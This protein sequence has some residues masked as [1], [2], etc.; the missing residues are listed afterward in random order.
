MAKTEKHRCAEHVH[1]WGRGAGFHPCV[2]NGVVQ[3]DG[4]WWC[5]QHAPSAVQ[6]RKEAREAKYRQERAV[7]QAAADRARAL[8][9]RAGCQVEN[10]RSWQHLTPT[11]DVRLSA[12]DLDRLLKE[13]GR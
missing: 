13:A 8:G 3:E 4:R 1:D 11:G 12:A 2:R 10:V 6:A 7:A 9:E 5:R